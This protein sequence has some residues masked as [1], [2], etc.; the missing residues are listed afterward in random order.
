V[1]SVIDTAF[2]SEVRPFNCN[3]KLENFMQLSDCKFGET[4]FLPWHSSVIRNVAQD[5][6]QIPLPQTNPDLAREK[7]WRRKLGKKN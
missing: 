5:F 6:E 7:R 4:T 1:T 2:L 3:V